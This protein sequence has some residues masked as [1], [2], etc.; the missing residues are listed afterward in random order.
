MLL[1]CI[2]RRRRANTPKLS[3]VS[4]HV[5]RSN[6][7]WKTKYEEVCETLADTEADLAEFQVSSKELEEEMGL[8]LERAEKA[9]EE[10]R[11][12][13]SKAETERDDWKVLRRLSFDSN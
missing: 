3:L 4:L 2:H 5:N 11:N 6:E 12:K 7:D 9:K 8:E 13:L 1:I 10:M